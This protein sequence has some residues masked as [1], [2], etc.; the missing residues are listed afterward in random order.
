M[1]EIKKYGLII[2]LIAGL[3]V[4]CEDD[5]PLVE[6]SPPLTGVYTLTNMVINVDATT[7]S[8]TTLAFMT[9]QN[10]LDSLTIPAGTLILTTST[11][12]SDQDSVPIG[13]T[14]TLSGDGSANLSGLLPVNW[15]S[16]CQP[17]L[18]ISDLGSDGTWSADTSTG[19]F[20]LDLVTDLLDING[21]FVLMGDQLEVTYEAYDGHDDRVISSVRYLEV[22]VSVT[23]ACLPVSTVTERVLTLS[24]D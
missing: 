18:L 16:G 3:I 7:L 12:Y 23:P 17:V 9:P 8:D 13:G 24:L 20:D 4:G 14:V 22:D 11:N 19:I 2:F 6:N 5:D 21:S 10:G 15:G 1:S